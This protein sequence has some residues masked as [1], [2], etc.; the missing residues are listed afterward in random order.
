MRKKKVKQSTKTSTGGY[1]F[2]AIIAL[3]VITSI[4]IELLRKFNDKK[5]LKNGVDNVCTI[6]ELSSNKTQFAKYSYKVDG[7][8]YYSHR[9]TPFYTI[10]PGEMFK[11]KYL[12]EN[13]E[14][15]KILYDYPLI[16]GQ[17]Q[18]RIK[19][20]V[21]KV[22]RSNKAMFKYKYNGV[23][24]ERWQ[25]LHDGHS[26]NQGDSIDVTVIETNPKIGILQY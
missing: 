18:I 7:K 24:Y 25:L 11:M 5:V 3:G 1:V 23:Q 14:I 19:G 15:D 26:I 17:K 2:L 12:R 21:Q 4:G 8:T 22:L 16:K 20:Y 13:P 9:A 10:Y 6:I